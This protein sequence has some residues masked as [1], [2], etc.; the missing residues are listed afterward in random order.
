MENDA[1][2][3]LIYKTLSGHFER[4]YIVSQEL[5]S[6]SLD[7]H[8]VATEWLNKESHFKYLESEG[9]PS[10]PSLSRELVSLLK[11][12]DRLI[13]ERDRVVELRAQEELDQLPEPLADEARSV[14]ELDWVETLY[15][16]ELLSED[17]PELLALS[18]RFARLWSDALL[19]QISAAHQLTLNSRSAPDPQPERSEQCGEG[20]GEPWVAAQRLTPL[21]SARHTPWASLQSLALI[22][23]AVTEAAQDLSGAL[24]EL[25]EAWRAELKE[26]CE[27]EG[28][29]VQGQLWSEQV[30]PRAQ[31]WAEE[32]LRERL[33]VALSEDVA[34]SFHSLA[35]APRPRDHRVGAL[36]F[37]GERSQEVTIIFAKRDGQ[38]LAQRDIEW[39]PDHPEEICEAFSEI[40]IRTLVAP[41]ELAP[42]L[43]EALEYLAEGYQI[44]RVCP[45]GPVEITRPQNLSQEAQLALQLAQRYVAPLRFWA[46]AELLS[47]AERLLDEP[48]YRLIASDERSR[49][50][51]HDCLKGRVDSEWVRLRRRR[52]DKPQE[53]Q[54]SRASRSPEPSPKGSR[55]LRRGD[56]VDVE[57]TAIDGHRL[58][59]EISSPTQ[60]GRSVMISLSGSREHLQTRFKVG[61]R[62]KAYV[63]HD[64]P[65]QP[66]ANLTLRPIQRADTPPKAQRRADARAGDLRSQ[67]TRARQ[68]PKRHNQAGDS[69][70][71]SAEHET[72]KTLSS[73]FKKKR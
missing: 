5:K 33:V 64:H 35:S 39:D 31:R 2:L 18:L 50:L 49:D 7:L 6:S 24:L 61:Q 3:A 12:C 41:T 26:L 27:R 21:Q 10:E 29:S 71:P 62:L 51:Y 1:Q 69:S 67:Q 11:D 47:F 60:L 63:I 19:E 45:I 28:L 54:A 58:K 44:A 23:E 66:H 57:L 34:D 4:P 30:T 9:L 13:Q 40:K 17:H 48:L 43:E 36:V 32:L 38:I 73:L 15:E 68:A 42:E 59:G 65:K 52:K 56:L 8:Q 14:A 46:R 55:Q 72:L 37:G 53:P 22:K 25:E 16:E 70:D 20:E